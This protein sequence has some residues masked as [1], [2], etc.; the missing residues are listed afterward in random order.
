MTKT[1]EKNRG[2]A[3]RVRFQMAS[4]CLSAINAT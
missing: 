4:D 1:Q 3:Q 2:Y